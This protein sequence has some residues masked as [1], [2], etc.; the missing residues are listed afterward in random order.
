M[1]QYFLKRY[2]TPKLIKSDFLDLAILVNPGV[3]PAPP[4]KRKGFEKKFVE[5]VEVK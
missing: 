1:N 2:D 5:I 4:S 3:D